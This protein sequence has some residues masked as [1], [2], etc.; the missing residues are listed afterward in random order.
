MRAKIAMLVLGSNQLN[1]YQLDCM[2]DCNA[3]SKISGVYIA[4]GRSVNLAAVTACSLCW[5]GQSEFKSCV[6]NLQMA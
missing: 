2:E 6:G 3:V 1:S 5:A 4:S